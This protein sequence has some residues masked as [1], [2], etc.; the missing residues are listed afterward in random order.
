MYTGVGFGRSAERS[1]AVGGGEFNLGHDESLSAIGSSSGTL[2]TWKAAELTCTEVAT[3]ARARWWWSMKRDWMGW[4]RLTRGLISMDGRFASFVNAIS[5]ELA[6]LG[7]RVRMER[8][9]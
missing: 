4:W 9:C 7:S 6:R 2:E 8:D 1:E 5:S 3:K